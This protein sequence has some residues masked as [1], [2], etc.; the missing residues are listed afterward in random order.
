[1]KKTKVNNPKIN[2]PSYR[3]NGEI[4]IEGSPLV[5]LIKPN[6]ENIVCHIAEAK[7]AAREA[8][9]DLIE[10]S[11]NAQPPV[12]KIADYSKFLYELK[13][14]SKKQLHANKPL[15]EIQLSVSIAE[16][17]MKTKASKAREFLL[18]GSKVKV[19]LSMKGREKARREENKKSI[20]EFITLLEDV[21]VPE[22]MPKDEGDSKTIVILKKKQNVK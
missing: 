22:S 16:N 5:R 8:E 12:L 15:K 19:I 14:A 9:L 6:G 2:I 18:D 4:Y 20:Y 21:A 3:I 13:K 7:E 10:I 1:M 11:P 17:D